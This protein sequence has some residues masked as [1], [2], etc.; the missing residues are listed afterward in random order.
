MSEKVRIEISTWSI[1]KIILVAALFYLLYLVKDIIAL[2]FIVLILVATFRPVVNKWERHIGRV[3]SV[4]VL[5]AI[6]FAI[7]ALAI[8]LIIPPLISQT[9]E[10][11]SSIPAVFE[12]YDLLTNYRPVI[13]SN[14]KNISAG[15]VT[16][17]FISITTGVFGGIVTFF[18]ALI[19]TVYLLLD[20]KSFSKSTVA[21]FPSAQREVAVDLIKKISLKVGNWFRGQMFLGLTI[22]IIDL[23]ALSVIGVP[24]ALALAIISGLLEIVPTIGPLIS[25]AVAAVVALSISPVKALIVVALYLIVQQLEGTI[26]VPKIMQKAVGLSPAI[27]IITILIGAKLFGVVGV[28]LA[29]PVAA[30]I[31]VVLQEWPSISSSFKQK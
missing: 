5:S 13:E 15:N 12:K 7:L 28:L 31:S 21:F 29:V 30:S 19:L 18:L 3:L 4:I 9:V 20:K 24:Y 23:I 8:Y 10:L 11:I 26:L 17:S 1:V 2:V 22:A 6:A 16:S 27:I 25:G 14:L